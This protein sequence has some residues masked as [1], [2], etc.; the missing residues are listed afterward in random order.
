V[1]ARIENFEKEVTISL[2]TLR[3]EPELHLHADNQD[4]KAAEAEKSSKFVL[5]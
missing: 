1:R 4:V 2:I 3:S 5:K